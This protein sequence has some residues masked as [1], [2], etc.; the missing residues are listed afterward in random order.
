M[1]GKP[2]LK[3][4]TEMLHD[5]KLL[6]VDPT[7]RWCWCGCLMLAAEQDDH[8]RLELAPGVP[9]TDEDIAE[10]IGVSQ[11]VWLMARD[12]FL[13]LAMLERD[14][15]MLI[16]SKYDHRQAAKDKTGA[17]RQGR[18][19]DSHLPQRNTV[20]PNV[21]NA[22]RDDVSNAVISR[23]E[24]E[25]E[26]ELE[27]EAEERNNNNY[28][29]VPLE[30]DTASATICQAWEAAGMLLTKTISDELSLLAKDHGAA[31]VCDAI[32]EAARGGQD[33]VTIRYIGGILRRWHSQGHKSA[34]TN[35]HES[36]RH[37]ASSEP[38]RTKLYGFWWE[39]QAGKWI[40]TGE[41]AE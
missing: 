33:K 25:A 15:A 30:I 10:S 35:G 20:T 14:G 7:W 41:A 3:L 31:W 29:S 39:Q 37:K 32:V 38:L 27:S 34:S 9:L 11:D 26:A 16:V 18:W 5:R 23:V 19:R 4:W 28:D 8:G 21:S 13:R 36:T 2:W 17:E 40:N 6:R 1:A 22:L 24:L 12:Y